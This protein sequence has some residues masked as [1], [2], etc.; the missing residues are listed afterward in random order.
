[1][2]RFLLAFLLLGSIMLNAQNDG[3]DVG[4]TKYQSWSL[5][6]SAGFFI[7]ADNQLFYYSFG[8]FP[9]YNFW[10]PK[11]YLSFSVGTPAN[12]GLEFAAANGSSVLLW[13]VDL[14]LTLD[15]NLGARATK[16]NNSPLGFFAGGGLNYNFMN[17]TLNGEPFNFHTFGPV[18]HGGFRFKINGRQSGIRLSY[19]DGFGASSEIVNGIIVEG[20]PGNRVFSFSFLYNL[21]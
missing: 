1:M 8:V 11:D 17:I 9:R 2:K 15:F 13:M 7:Q 6:A 3:S 18:V 12:L 4:Y 16:F 5:E 21:N 20:T 14:P 10:A 19:L